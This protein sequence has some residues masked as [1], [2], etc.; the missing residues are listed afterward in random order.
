MYRYISKN[1]LR[2]PVNLGSEKPLIDN[3]QP[4]INIYERTT[5]NYQQSINNC[6]HFTH[7]RKQ[8]KQHKK[9]KF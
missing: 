6:E 9:V 5:D 2:N 7:K 3:H 4:T 8:R 1:I